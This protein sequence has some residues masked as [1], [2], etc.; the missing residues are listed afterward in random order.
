VPVMMLLKPGGDFRILHSFPNLFV[1]AYCCQE[2]GSMA[3][4][5]LNRL[6]G[7]RSH[8]R[9]LDKMERELEH[10]FKS[11]MPV[12]RLRMQ[13]KIVEMGQTNPSGVAC[14]LLGRYHDPNPNVRQGVGRSLFELAKSRDFLEAVVDRIGD[15]DR[16]IRRAMFDFLGEYKGFHATSFLSFYEQTLMLIALGRKKEIPTNDIQA[17]VNVSKFAFLDGRVMDGMKDIA[18][19]LDLL[20]HR[21]RNV[22]QLKSYL[23]DV[24]R[25]A[26]ELSR[27]GIMSTRLEEPFQKALKANKQR[28]YD[29]TKEI[30]R[31]RMHESE[32]RT[33]LDRL[34][35]RIK[36]SVREFPQMS[37][38]D[39]RGTD[40]WVLSSLQELMDIVISRT[41]AGKNIDAMEALRSFLGEDFK[42]FYTESMEE[43]LTQGDPS[44]LFTLY[45]VGI[46]CLKLASPLLPVQTE[47][48]YQKYYR[49]LEEQPSIHVVIW[50]ELMMRLIASES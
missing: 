5:K 8:G 19:C 50:P 32:L 17:L 27:M 38:S 41:L 36:S 31:G 35:E 10:S 42:G 13:R 3:D 49:E 18:T 16:S 1:L 11:P 40:V 48:V 9:E 34:G 44:A 20:K 25:I 14:V 33:E 29:E 21:H 15:P 43:R 46:S 39:L 45:N 30:I 37:V 4:R 24:L 22:E 26:P 28:T 6:V 23:V 7:Q 2:S 12:E 47:E